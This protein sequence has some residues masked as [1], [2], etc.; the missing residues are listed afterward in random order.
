[1]SN[2]SSAATSSALDPLS[3]RVLNM[4]EV[5]SET[6]LRQTIFTLSLPMKEP[7]TGNLFLSLSPQRFWATAEELAESNNASS[8]NTYS[9]IVP[10][11]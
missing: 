9:S 2:K 6:S 3:E 8:T 1:L 11:L 5:R 4:S 7:T 10:K